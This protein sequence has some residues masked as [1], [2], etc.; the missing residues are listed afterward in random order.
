MEHMK[1]NGNFAG[2]VLSLLL[3]LF[4]VSGC[5]EGDQ[6]TT[7]SVSV[8]SAT[9]FQPKGTIQGKIRDAVTLDPIVNATVSIGLAMTQ[10]D[11]RG[12]Y[13][14]ANVPATTDALNRTVSGSYK[15]TVDLR[16]VTSPVNMSVATTGPR[17]PNFR[18]QDVQVQYTSLDDSTPC[19]DPDT[20][21]SSTATSTLQQCG[22]N[23]TNHDTPVDGLVANADVLV[24]KLASNIQGVVAG[25]SE[26]VGDFFTPVANATVTLTTATSSSTDENSGTGNSGN[27]MALAT[28][29]A[30]GA[31]IFKN[32]EAGRSFTIK[33]VDNVTAPTKQA[34]T[35]KTSPEDGQTLFLTV[36]EST[37]LHLCP[38]D[39]HGPT[40]TAVSPEPGSD[41]AA[42]TTTVTLQ[43]SESVKQTVEAGVDP[44]GRGNLFDTIEVR[45]DGH[46][47]D[48]IPSPANIPYTLAWN[49]TFDQLTVSF[50]TGTSALYRVTLPNVGT[51]K[52][53]NG[54]AAAPGTCP[55]NSPPPWDNTEG[56]GQTDDDCVVYFTTKGGATPSTPVLTLVNVA[57]MDQAGS[58]TGIFDWPSVSGAKTYNFY[59]RT[60]QVYFDGLIQLGAVELVSPLLTVSNV[61]QNL[62]TFLGAGDQHALRYDCFVRGVNSDG[63]EG[64]DSNTVTARDAVGPKMITGISLLNTNPTAN[65]TIDEVHL[66]FNEVVDETTAEVAGSYVFSGIA[67]PPS[68]SSV[69]QGGGDE[70]ILT[71]SET[72]TF[73][74][75]TAAGSVLTV[76]GVKDV[77]LVSIDVSGN[78]YHLDTGVVD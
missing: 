56:L 58:K 21:N 44:S 22:T 65:S 73:G 30:A 74:G 14:L 71:I 45:S 78:V 48:T 51:L 46:K 9:T 54:K 57:G 11:E 34:T 25:C 42:G 33:A 75:L 53:A 77:G 8:P 17:Y 60:N 18:Y 38:I 20:G 47:V 32:I 16:L 7:T 6:S 55:V 12:Q 13:I 24:G 27:L 40:I 15:M 35:S 70:V 43:F 68:V 59:C 31:F 52:D 67:S 2:V 19:P 49:P 66:F 39:N 72:Q 62:S 28:T 64:Q 3:T 26:S 36:Q 37:A 10:T 69:K 29:D 4:V 63:V 23:N 5:S 41:Q 61:S 76:T 50:T 1:W